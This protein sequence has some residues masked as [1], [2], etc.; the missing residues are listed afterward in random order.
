MIHIILL[1]LIMVPAIPGNFKSKIYWQKLRPHGFCCG[2]YINIPLLALAYAAVYNGVDL[3]RN[4]LFTN[5][6]EFQR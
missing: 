2:W 3:C 4:M 1:L 6:G 5:I